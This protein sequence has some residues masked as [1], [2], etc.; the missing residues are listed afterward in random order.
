MTFQCKVGA[1]PPV[2]NAI[3]EAAAVENIRPEGNRIPVALIKRNSAGG[4]VPPEELVILRMSDF[5]PILRLLVE[6]GHV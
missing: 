5:L 2:W 6:T 4:G 1:R 3:K